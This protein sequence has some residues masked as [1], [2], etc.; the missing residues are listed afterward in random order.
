MLWIAVGTLVLTV[1]LYIVIPKG[2]FPTQD[3]GLIQAV[4]Q[5]SPTVSFAAMSDRQQA[6]A[7]DIL[8]DPHVV[9]LSSNVGVDGTNT[10]LNSGRFLINLTSRDSRWENA[11]DIIRDLQKETAASPA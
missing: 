7:A 1:L 6:L 4:S 8:K 5:A 9:S 2:F 3:T 11:S 10:T